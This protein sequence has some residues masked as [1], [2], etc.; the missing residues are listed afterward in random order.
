M[1][2]KWHAQRVYVRYVYAEAPQT[3]IMMDRNPIRE[4][5]KSNEPCTWHKDGGVLPRL[6]I[7][8]AF[9][10]NPSR[11]LKSVRIQSSLKF[12]QDHHNVR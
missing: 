2:I 5:A 3:M 12:V 7:I 11:I 6:A 1:C 8:A 4:N 10:H 9:C